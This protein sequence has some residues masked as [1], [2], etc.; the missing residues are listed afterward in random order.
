MVKFLQRRFK[1]L[2]AAALLRFFGVLWSKKEVS[3]VGITLKRLFLTNNSTKYIDMY[4]KSVLKCHNAISGTFETF[5]FDQGC[6]EKWVEAP[7]TFIFDPAT[8]AS[9]VTDAWVHGCAGARSRGLA[10]LRHG[11]TDA[12]NRRCTKPRVCGCAEPR[13]SLTQGCADA[14]A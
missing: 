9:G 11:C 13:A 14:S 7:E 8:Q 1:F 5:I 12:R 4:S 10:K 2:Q 3:T 6:R